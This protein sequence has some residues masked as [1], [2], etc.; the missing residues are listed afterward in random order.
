MKIFLKIL[1]S[2]LKLQY[3]FE[4]LQLTFDFLQKNSSLMIKNYSEWNTDDFSINA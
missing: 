3:L 4:I 2:P 1:Q